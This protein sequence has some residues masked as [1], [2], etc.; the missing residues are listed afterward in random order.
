MKL[1]RVLSL[2]LALLM[3]LTMTSFAASVP[4]FTDVDENAS[5]AESVSVLTALK[6]ITGYDDGTFKPDDKIKRSEFAAIITRTLGMGDLSASQAGG[7]F[8]DVPATHW[9]SGYIAMAYQAGI[10]NGMGDGT[11]A[12]EEDVTYEQ[13]VKMLVCALGYYPK[14]ASL[15]G[16][17]TGYMLVANQEGVTIGTAPTAGGSPR[18]TVARLVNNALTVPLM[19][20]V[21][22]GKDATFQRIPN[23]SLLYTKLKAIKVDAK[24]QVIPLDKTDRNVRMA[25]KAIDAVSKADG[26][27]INLDSNQYSVAQLNNSILRNN[28]DLAG[29]QG[30]YVSAYVDVN[31]DTQPKLIMATPKTGKNDYV[32]VDPTLLSKKGIGADVD[33]TYGYVRY[34]KNVNDDKTSSLTLN[35][36]SS[37]NVAVD[38]YTNLV[39]DTALYT[40]TTIA[41]PIVKVGGNVGDVV[42]RYVDTDGDGSYDTIFAINEKAFVVGSVNPSS[43]RINRD[44]STANSATSFNKAFLVLDPEDETVNATIKD[45]DGKVI[46]FSDINVGDVANVRVSTSG[47]VDYYEIIITSNEVD[48]QVSEVSTE[49]N[50]VTAGTETTF[51]IGGVEYKIF[52]GLNP[53]KPGDN[54]VAK[55]SNDGKIISY[56]VSSEFRNYGLVIATNATEEFGRTFQLQMMTTL[57]DVVILNLNKRLNGGSSDIYNSTSYP[58]LAAAEAAFKADYPVGSLAV[59]E[60]NT[61][62]EIKNI[63]LNTQV[64]QLDP[65]LSGKAITAGVYVES[66][67]RIGSYY[68]ADNT[69]F[70][71]IDGTTPASIT[72]D[73]VMLSGQSALTD[74]MNYTGFAIVEDGIMKAVMLYDTGAVVNWNSFPM[75]ITNKSSISIEGDTRVKYTGFVDGVTT[76]ITVA[77]DKNI[78][79]AINDIIIYGINGAN[80]MV[81]AVKL[82]GLNGTRYEVAVSTSLDEENKVD[83]TYKNYSLSTAKCALASDAVVIP[84]AVES[85]NMRG[86]SIAGKSYEVRGRTLRIINNYNATFSTAVPGTRVY[87]SAPDN[88]D[89]VDDYSFNSAANAYVYNAVTKKMRVSTIGE[90]MTDRSSLDY[91]ATTASPLGSA[92]KTEGR[93]NDDSVYLYKYDGTTYLVL[94]IDAAGD[95]N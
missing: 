64:N 92:S 9:A 29:L 70:F 80:E 16:Y 95:N 30:L 1:T 54:I 31:D 66:S 69:A 88:E 82:G 60:T 47:S 52:T 10:I 11:F 75:A 73:S 77:A 63:R 22:W 14:A 15:G 5:Y 59:Y 27:Y 45:A 34:Y 79:Y 20:Q 89:Y 67:E 50:K 4:T 6:I 57:G 83:T 94:I 32:D 93:D 21:V 39:L 74:S 12:P 24:I 38:V 17:P 33:D 7:I 90:L 8:T 25:Y 26:W 78:N 61:A 76:E 13:V 42:Y 3:V 68:F 91:A 86:F 40:N 23:Q 36:D 81:N 72:K 53:L 44:T 48:G 71:A 85:G 65:N 56:Q 55:I 35:R 28:V 84:A 43:Y 41:N 51:I 49:T 58:T 19:D 18:S 87:G 2:V 62:N 37:N 46:D